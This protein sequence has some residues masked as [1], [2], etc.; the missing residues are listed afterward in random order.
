MSKHLNEK[1][2]CYIGTSG[3]NYQDWR[4]IFYPPGLAT[5]HWLGFYAEHF[6]SV[7]VNATFYRNFA[8]KIYVKWRESVPLG[9]KYVLKVPRVVTHQNYLKNCQ[10]VIQTFCRSAELLHDKLGLYLLQL[11]PTM[12]YD[13]EALYQAILT[14]DEPNKV[15]VEFRHPQWFTAEVYQLLKETGCIICKTDSPLSKLNYYSVGET[16][17]L[18]LH[19][20]TVW[21]DYIYTENELTEVTSGINKLF[22]HGTK[23]I[24]LFFN[25]TCH[26]QAVQ[27]AL[28]MKKNCRRLSHIIL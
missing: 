5:Q 14:F 21:Y 7:E 25:N 26:G 17:Y 20:R 1:L 13:L 19:G 15:V 23:K 16:A 8:D 9:F 18:R 6:S 24:F 10:A 12:P 11:A 2:H 3:W 28:T 22:S 27:N 4:G